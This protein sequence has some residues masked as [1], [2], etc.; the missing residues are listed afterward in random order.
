M[1][2]GETDGFRTTHELMGSSFLSPWEEPFYNRRSP[3]IVEELGRTAQVVP[4][5]TGGALVREYALVKE[6]TPKTGLEI[7]PAG[8][9]EFRVRGVVHEAPYSYASGEAKKAHLAA[10]AEYARLMEET[11][12]PEI[13]EILAER[14]KLVR[15]HGGFAVWEV[16]DVFTEEELWL[17]D[18]ARIEKKARKIGETYERSQ[19]PD[20]ELAE[21][22]G[23]LLAEAVRFRLLM[24]ELARIHAEAFTKHEALNV[25]GTLGI[26]A[27]YL[28]TTWWLFTREVM[29]ELPE[30]RQVNA[31]KESLQKTFFDRLH[32]RPPKAP[33][34]DGEEVLLG[35]RFEFPRFGQDLSFEDG[36]LPNAGPEFVTWFD[37]MA[38][39]PYGCCE[40]LVHCG[41]VT[42]RTEDWPNYPTDEDSPVP[43]VPDELFEEEHYTEEKTAHNYNWLES[44]HVDAFAQGV[45]GEPD[46]E[47]TPNW[48]VRANFLKDFQY[49]Y[50]GEFF[51][52][53]AR[54]FPNLTWGKADHSPFLYSGN[55]FDTPYLTSAEAVIVERNAEEGYCLAQ[56]EWRGKRDIKVYPT[57]FAEYRVGDRVTVLKD[58]A[59]VKESQTWKDEDMKP[60]NFDEEVWRIAPLTYYGKGF[61]W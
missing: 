60:E 42:T 8:R 5:E 49:P 52:L 43:P 50:P 35:G 12:P 14:N 17:Y 11:T 4:D 59:T 58:V 32:I 13:R 6:I 29:Q 54:I 23:K 48:W 7:L 19:R 31:S 28:S 46:F 56:I 25:Y 34:G 41:E 44:D 36:R 45:S 53:A 27:P 33:D 38:G 21:E 20:P 10:Q 3:K 22:F 24:E 1:L 2:M 30:A 26:K 15:E 55:Y 47:N 39:F 61:D 40:M 51:G 18:F 57:D 16:D 9:K 37:F